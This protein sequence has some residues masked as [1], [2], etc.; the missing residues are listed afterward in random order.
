[1]TDEKL[2]ECSAETTGVYIRL[3]CLMHKSQEYGVI[4]L[5]QKDKQTGKQISD[6][7]LKITRQMPYTTDTIERAL[8][9]LL[10]EHGK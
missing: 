5:K 10:E 9:E 7:A 3:M 4:L 2:A 8:A 1:M 6:F